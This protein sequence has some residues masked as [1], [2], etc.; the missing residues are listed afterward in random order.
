MATIDALIWNFEEDNFTFA[1]S[2]VDAISPEAV[3][4]MQYQNDPGWSVRYVDLM[5]GGVQET[6]YL[7]L[8]ANGTRY[9]DLSSLGEEENLYWLT[10]KGLYLSD[11]AAATTGT[12]SYFVERRNIDLNDIV[13]EFTTSKWIHAKQLYFH[14]ASQLQAEVQSVNIFAIQVGWSDS[15][16]DEPKWLPLSNI[17]LQT[18][19]SGGRVKYDF[20]STGRYLA[21]RMY[22]DTTAEIKMTGA[23]IDVV[24]AHGR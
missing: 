17:N 5:P 19:E 14:L 23:E 7:S 11:Q 13:G 3:I 18:R 16:M 22:F 12:K 8:I 10:A 24:Q 21:L 20:R 15:L 6:T 1:D 9:V 4:C 2:W